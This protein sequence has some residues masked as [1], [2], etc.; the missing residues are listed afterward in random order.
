[1]RGVS[2]SCA[3]SGVSLDRQGAGAA[4]CTPGGRRAAAW[5]GAWLTHTDRRAA[6]WEGSRVKHADTRAAAWEGVWPKASARSRLIDGRRMA[7]SAL[8][9]GLPRRQATAC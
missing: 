5:Q 7:V 9:D 1:V 4:S 2:D 6:A 8:T 3:C